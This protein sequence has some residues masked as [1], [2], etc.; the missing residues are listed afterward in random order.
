MPT[1][2]GP[3]GSNHGGTV[4]TM[5]DGAGNINVVSCPPDSTITVSMLRTA[6][7]PIL[8]FSGSSAASAG[9]AVAAQLEADGANA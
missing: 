6:P 9:S 8:I 2:Y 1:T 3:G 4:I 7:D 5:Y